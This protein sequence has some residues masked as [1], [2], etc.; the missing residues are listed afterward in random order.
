LTNG[1][2]AFSLFGLGWLSGIVEVLGGLLENEALINLGLTVSMFVPSDALWR[3]ASFFVQSSSM[4]VAAGVFRQA[5]PI[6][7]NA[8]PTPALIVW[9]LLYP[10]ILLTSAIY[11]FSR[12]DL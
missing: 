12:R 4:I 3:S 9:G 7:A 6:L 10:L 5:L 11:V 1:A 2:I 8:P